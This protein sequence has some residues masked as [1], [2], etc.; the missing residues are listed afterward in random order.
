MMLRLV[1]SSSSLTIENFIL[2]S[3]IDAST[4]GR[5]KEILC[6]WLSSGFINFF[7]MKGVII[8]LICLLH[9]F[10]LQNHNSN[11]SKFFNLPLSR[12]CT[13][14]IGRGFYASV[15]FCSSNFVHALAKESNNNHFCISTL[16]M[17][18]NVCVG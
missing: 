9:D 17:T 10:D 5:A 4:F 8:C 2:S 11:K 13:L 15:P 12:V 14:Y 16:W 3:C 18:P 6:L 7:A 1:C